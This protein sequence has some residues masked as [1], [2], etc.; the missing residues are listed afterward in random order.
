[1][2]QE[3][4]PAQGPVDV[5]VSRLPAEFVENGIKLAQECTLFGIPLTELSRDELL[6]AAAEG[7]RAYNRHLEQS[8]KS[9]ELMRDLRRAAG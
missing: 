1:M 9:W 3:P 6:A 4:L 2:N 5:N 8:I 7:W